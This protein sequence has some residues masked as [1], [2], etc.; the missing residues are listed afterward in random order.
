MG[1]LAVEI[2]AAAVVLG[3]WESTAK[4]PVAAISIIFLIFAILV[5]FF[6]PRYYGEIEFYLSCLKVLTIVIIIVLGLLIDL[7]ASDQGPI[8]FK[9][10]IEQPFPPAYLGIKGAKGQFLSFW[11]VIMQASF[12]FFGSDVPGIG[13]VYAE[14]KCADML[15]DEAETVRAQIEEIKKN[16]QWGQPYVRKLVHRF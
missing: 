7:G 3:Y 5:N 12:S 13:T 1:S 4:I 14:K 15:E 8:G 11:A 10:W 16:R 6:P 2:T 9:Y